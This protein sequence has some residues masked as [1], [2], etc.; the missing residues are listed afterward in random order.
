MATQNLSRRTC[1]EPALGLIEVSMDESLQQLIALVCVAAVVGIALVRRSRK[2]KKSSSCGHGTDPANPDTDEDG[3]GRKLRALGRRS[4]VQ[5][6]VRFCE[7]STAFDEEPLSAALALTQSD[8]AQAG[9][10][11]W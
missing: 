9:A 2:K 8:A 10:P 7:T 3:L 4:P 6:R 1:G 5:Q 11:N